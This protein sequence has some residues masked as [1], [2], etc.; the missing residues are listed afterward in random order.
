MTAAFETDGGHNTC[1][2]EGLPHQPWRVFV[3]DEMTPHRVDAHFG[4]SNVTRIV[5][6]EYL[7][8]E[9]QPNPCRGACRDV[10]MYDVLLPELVGGL[11][12]Y[13]KRS[14]GDGEILE[15]AVKNDVVGM[16]LGLFF[17]FLRQQENR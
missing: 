5:F 9:P 7:P 10:G 15:P 4:I 8:R 13:K 16:R 3:G 17:C 12:V 6:L 14:P 11:A 1:L 2:G